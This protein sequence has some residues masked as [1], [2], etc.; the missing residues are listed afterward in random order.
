MIWILS[1]MFAMILHTQL[2]LWTLLINQLQIA[3]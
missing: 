3:V 2:D 1:E